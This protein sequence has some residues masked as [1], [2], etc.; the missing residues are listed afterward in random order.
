MVYLVLDS[1]GRRTGHERARGRERETHM[2]DF[3]HPRDRDC[4]D[5][6]AIPYRVFGKPL[7]GGID[8]GNVCN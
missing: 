1:L 6:G 8:A 5:S 2:S 3:E 7:D 4:N